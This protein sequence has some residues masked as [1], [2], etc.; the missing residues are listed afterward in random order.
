MG[1]VP[2]RVKIY[3]IAITGMSAAQRIKQRLQILGQR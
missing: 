3:V 1:M 2:S